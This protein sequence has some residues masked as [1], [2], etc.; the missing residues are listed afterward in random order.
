MGLAAPPD[1]ESLGGHARTLHDVLVERGPS[2]A[3]DLQ[4]ASRR[5]PDHFEMGLTELIARGLVTCDAFAGLRRLLV[6]PSKRPARMR[7]APFLPP[8]RWALLR[9]AEH[10]PPEPEFAAEQL[11]RRWGVVF[12]RL[13]ERER[14]DIPWRVLHRTYRRMEL[15]GEVHGGRFVGGFAGEQFAL[16]DAVR[17]LRKTRR[18]APEP[19]EVAAADPLNLRGIL[20]PDPRVSP[21]ARQ[22][23]VVG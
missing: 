10:E 11:L 3:M 6:S 2:F 14:M 23:V 20:T 9:G 1:T 4:A 7:K 8:G 18:E 17:A 16:P 21:Q 15:R 12:R 13:L 5:L 22:S 19:F